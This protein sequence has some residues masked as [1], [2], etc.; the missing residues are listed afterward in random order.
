[1]FEN[2]SES[3]FL[4]RR[5][6]FG[7][8]SAL[9]LIK[10][11]AENGHGDEAAATGRLALGDPDCPD[12]AEIEAILRTI[13]SEPDGWD[14]ALRNFAQNPSEERWEE[15]M[16]FVPEDVFYQRLRTTVPLLMRLRCDGNVLFR[17]ASRLGLTPDL[18]DLAASGTVDPATI[19]NRAR[20]SPASSAWLGLA[21]QAAFARGDRF[22][23][24]RYLRDA[25]SDDEQA[26][27]AWASISEIRRIADEQFNAELDKLGVPQV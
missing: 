12:R 17:C 16:R 18:F 5:W 26:F 3:R 8:E 9:P 22:G 6:F 27:F 13:A 11:L 15:L 20:E 23:C 21:A 1:M 19:E 2:D 25:V 7:G 4:I 14:E 10:R 24:M